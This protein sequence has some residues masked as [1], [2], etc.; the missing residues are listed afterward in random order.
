MR[1]AAGEAA[2]LSLK[3]SDA[4]S[5]DA[6]VAVALNV[7]ANA[8]G[9]ANEAL[10]VP[11]TAA[12]TAASLIQPLVPVSA[13]CTRIESAAG[14]FA[15][16]RTTVSPAVYATLSV[17]R[18]GAATVDVVPVVAVSVEDEAVPVVAVSV[19]EDDVPARGPTSPSEAETS[20][21]TAKSAVKPTT[22]RIRTPRCERLRRIHPTPS[23]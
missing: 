2:E 1:V 10:N 5:P 12:V 11:A 21:P 9:S 8:A 23:A 7:E 16:E 13:T 4:V 15:P 19:D 14:Q 20:R 18:A 17:E 22:N 3:L 6:S